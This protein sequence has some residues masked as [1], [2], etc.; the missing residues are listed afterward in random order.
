MNQSRSAVVNVINSNLTFI[1][2]CSG[3]K[4]INNGNY[5]FSWFVQGDTIAFS[6]SAFTSGF[7]GIGFNAPFSSSNTVSLLIVCLTVF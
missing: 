7:V 4:S 2:D 5:T 1:I 3:F 6:I